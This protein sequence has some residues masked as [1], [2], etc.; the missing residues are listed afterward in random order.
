MATSDFFRDLVVVELA[1]VLAGPAVGQFFAELGARVIKVE[2]RRTGGDVTR[3]WR[4]RGEDPERSYSAYYCSTDWGKERRLMDLSDPAERETALELIAGAD[5]LISNFKPASATRLGL[6][7][8]ALRARSPRLIYGQ[9]PSF[10][11][12]DEPPSLHVVPP[13]LARLPTL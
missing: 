5:V 7:A 10:C 4:Q 6:D 12:G 9:I 13:A 2:N 8:E 11:R 3:R 1:S